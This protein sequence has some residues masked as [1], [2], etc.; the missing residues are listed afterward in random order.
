MAHAVTLVTGA[1]I[2]A[3]VSRD[4]RPKTRQEASP[5]L[6]RLARALWDV[7]IGF[8][9]A[10]AV[11]LALHYSRAA[12]WPRETDLGRPRAGHDASAR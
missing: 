11:A 7:A 3:D 6:T 12:R 10:T 2:R 5:R 1:G 4:E 8:G 9:L